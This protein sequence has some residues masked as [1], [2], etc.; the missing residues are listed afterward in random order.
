MYILPTFGFGIQKLPPR[1][2]PQVVN[3]HICFLNLTDSSPVCYEKLAPYTLIEQ[4]NMQI[5][6]VTLPL[7]NKYRRKLSLQY[8]VCIYSNSLPWKKTTN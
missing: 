8:I 3:I 7:I 2:Y 5:V 4:N 6:S 1:T